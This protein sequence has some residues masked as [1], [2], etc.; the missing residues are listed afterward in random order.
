MKRWILFLILL[1]FSIYSNAQSGPLRKDFICLSLDNDVLN[2]L[3]NSSDWGY[4]NG[5]RIDL[6]H[7][8][9]KKT[10]TT[11]FNWLHQYRGTNNNI[12]SGWGLMQKMIT[13]QNTKLSVPDRNDYPYC[14]A[15]YAVYTIHSA[16]NISKINLQSEYIAGVMGPPSLAK[17]T[18]T[19]VHH[20]VYYRIPKGWDYQLPTDLLLNYNIGLEKQLFSVKAISGVGQTQL[21]LG[22]MQDGLSLSLL[23]HIGNNDNYFSGIYNRYF[24]KKPKLS[25]SAGTTADLVLYNALLDG[26]LFNKESPFRNSHSKYGTDLARKKILGSLDMRALFS[27]KIFAVSYSL[28]ITS[29]EFKEFKSHIIGNISVYINLKNK[30]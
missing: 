4:T 17:Q 25:I 14:G 7:I 28:C 2:F 27:T 24:T 18:Q 9:V 1:L 5:F 13:P 23:M 21:F 26:G 22:S 30:D 8:P 10:R 29:S 19:F 3:R 12:T 11:I 6:F 20:L 16:D 15:L